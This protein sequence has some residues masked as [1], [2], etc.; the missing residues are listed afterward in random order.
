MAKVIAVCGAGGKTTFVYN[1]AKE[2]ASKGYKVA[3]TT[4]TKMWLEDVVSNSNYK[5][6]G[7]SNAIPICRGEQCE[8]VVVGNHDDKHLLP[9]SQQEYDKLCN[10]YDIVLIEADGSRMMPLKIPNI[11]KE[12]VI[13]HNINEIVV[14]Y[15]LQS[16]GRKLG[17]VCQRFEE[18]KDLIKNIIDKNINYDTIVDIEII[19]KFYTELYYKPLKEKYNIDNISLYLSDMTDN[20]NYKQYKNIALNI[21]ASGFSKRFGNNKLLYELNNKKLYKIVIDE[22]IKAKYLLIKK[23][24]ERYNYDINIDIS[25]V[26][27]YDDILND[28]DYRNRIITIK[29]DNSSNGQSESIKIATK[30][31]YDYDAICYFNCDT[32]N[33]DSA[34]IANMIFYFMCSN[35]SLGAIMTGNKLKNPAIFQKKY[36]DDIL[37]ISGDMGARFILSNN[38]KDCYAYHVDESMLYD[39]DTIEDIKNLI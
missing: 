39:I 18:Y 29:N 26:S 13:P 25:I 32:P 24:K 11:D 37:N 35:K 8:P 22:I 36:Y 31:F 23:I 33:I 20:T 10:D 38:I 5:N 30:T 14:V 12:P 15:G 17:V 1:K 21:S 16:V 27:Q 6:V 28:V 2:Y 7:A 3:I 4:T 34:E 19:N 9:L